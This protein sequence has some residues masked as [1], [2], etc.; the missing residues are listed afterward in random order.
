MSLTD[1]PVGGCRRYDSLECLSDVEYSGPGMLPEAYWV[2]L[3]DSLVIDTIRCKGD[4]CKSPY[5]GWQ[6]SKGIYRKGKKYYNAVR[7]GR[8]SKNAATGQ[9][10]CHFEGDSVSVNIGE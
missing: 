8:R 3:E 1:L 7:L 10:T 6:S 4:E 2:Y 5:I 9:F